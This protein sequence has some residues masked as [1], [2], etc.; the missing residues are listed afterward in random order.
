M[1]NYSQNIANKRFVTPE[2][3]AKDREAFNIGKLFVGL[4]EAC[5]TKEAD[6]ICWA[7]SKGTPEQRLK[8]LAWYVLNLRC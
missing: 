3:A 5:G 7:L 4:K 6:E 2:Q 8:W 1:G